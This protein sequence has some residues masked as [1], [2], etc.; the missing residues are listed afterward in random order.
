MFGKIELFLFFASLLQASRA[1]DDNNDDK[2]ISTP[3]FYANEQYPVSASQ[4]LY[5]YYYNDQPV[6]VFPTGKRFLIN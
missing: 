1:Y 3:I 4:W 6:S 2:A 5:N